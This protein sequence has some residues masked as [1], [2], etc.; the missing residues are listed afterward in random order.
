MA[1]KGQE[2]A[3]G[4]LE[5]L[6]VAELT[7]SPKA[8][9]LYLQSFAQG[10]NPTAAAELAVGAYLGHAQA[11][12]EGEAI[13]E[14]RKDPQARPEKCRHYSMIEGRCR[15]HG[16]EHVLF[17]RCKRR[18]CPQC[19][20]WIARNRANEIES[21]IETFQRQ[22]L[23][24][25]HFVGTFAEDVTPEALNRTV[26]YF[27]RRVRRY[28]GRKTGRR[29]EYV[30]V[31]ETSEAGRYHSHVLMSPWSYIPQASLSEW[32]QR[33]GGGPVVYVRAIGEDDPASEYLTKI[34]GQIVR[35]PAEAHAIAEYLGGCSRDTL[36]GVPGGKGYEVI[37]E[38]GK[39]SIAFSRGWP[40]IEAF[41]SREQARKGDIR[42]EVVR[43]EYT[44]GPAQA[45]YRGELVPLY[46]SDSVTEY[47][48]LHE[49]AKA[50]EVG[51]HCFEFV[52][53][54][55]Q[56]RDPDPPPAIF[57]PRGGCAR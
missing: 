31:D 14:W 27:I 11:K 56:A 1:R 5:G 53:G 51:C 39:R 37:V 16:I 25:A 48:W 9:D 30:R 23:R 20:A 17:V 24:V 15:E 45:V 49:I 6:S 7:K 33:Y 54:P 57:T 2:P 32:W 3:L 44:E 38:A 46:E 28:L 34:N 36:T 29:V 18:D 35:T 22:G 21:G 40:R 26:E 4:L 43:N 42:W 19:G 8:L 13:R 55:A 12:A 50:K 10:V 41:R 47:G 52:E